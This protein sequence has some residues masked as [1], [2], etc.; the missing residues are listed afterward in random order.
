MA[1]FYNVDVY[2]DRIPL[3]TVRKEPPLNLAEKQYILAVERGDLAGVRHALEEAEIYFN[4][5]INCKDPLGRSALLIA[6]Q[7]ENVE[8]IELVLR[9][10]VHVGSALL[11]AIDEEV[12]EAVEL[13]LNYKPP[14]K[15]PRVSKITSTLSANV[16]PTPTSAHFS[17][18]HF[19]FIIIS[20]HLISLR[21]ASN[22]TLL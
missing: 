16:P 14:K 3:H 1:A 22:S 21:L 20:S 12:V 18:L 10:H 4:I 11:H 2:S 6:I 15:D 19:M 5:N 8:I 9:H 17:P 13:L 7:N